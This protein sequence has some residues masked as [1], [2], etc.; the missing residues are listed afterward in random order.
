METGKGATGASIAR[1]GTVVGSQLALPALMQPTFSGHG[2]PGGS[3]G[4]AATTAL[5]TFALPSAGGIL[6]GVPPE[7]ITTATIRV[8]QNLVSRIVGAGGS[9][10][11]SLQEQTGT[12]LQID[13]STKELGFS[14]LCVKAKSQ[15]SVNQVEV[16]IDTFMQQSGGGA[17]PLPRP[18]MASVIPTI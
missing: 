10:I 8:P 5:G 9:M 3:A 2:L 7:D 12:D 6:D 17:Q 1:P 16:F 4:A 18:A 14:V 13:Q 15:S 11:R